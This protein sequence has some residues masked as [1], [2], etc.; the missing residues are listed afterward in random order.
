V[1]AFLIS[2]NATRD[3]INHG[4][5]RSLPLGALVAA[6]WAISCATTSFALLAAFVRFARPHR[7]LESLSRNAYGMYLTHY[8]LVTWLQYG[9]I[10]WGASPIL[11]AAIVM[12]LAIT[13]SWLLT[14]A[15]RRLPVVG[16]V[17]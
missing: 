2:G 7:L 1:A 16:R 4:Y 9:L 13:A 17:I 14:M 3:A 15:L 6:A 5:A 12:G 8:A 10:R 11:K